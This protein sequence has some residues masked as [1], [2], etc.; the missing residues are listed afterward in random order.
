[1]PLPVR[2]FTRG[3]HN[4][5]GFLPTLLMCVPA[6]RSRFRPCTYFLGAMKMKFIDLSAH[7]LQQAAAVKDFPGF[8]QFAALD[9]ERADGRAADEI[10][11]W[12]D[13][14]KFAG[15]FGEQRKVAVHL[16]PFGEQK[17]EFDFH[18]AENPAKNV[19]E[20]LPHPGWPRRHPGREVVIHKGRADDLLNARQATPRLGIIPPD[21]CFVRFGHKT[22][23]S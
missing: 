15:V 14:G 12:L 10:A 3:S 5:K 9:A 16:V 2:L 22:P 13:A 18:V 20:E 6:S 19:L 1:M 17:I 8:G 4:S 7:L 23:W 21:Q 11:L